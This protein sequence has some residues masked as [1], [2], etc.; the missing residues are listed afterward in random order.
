MRVCD[1]QFDT[2]AWGAIP[3]YCSCCGL[4]TLVRPSTREWPTCPTCQEPMKRQDQPVCD[5]GR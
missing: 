1:I 2:A 3:V 4:Q 5:K